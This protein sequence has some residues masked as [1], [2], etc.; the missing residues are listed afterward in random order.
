MRT[1]SR[2][3]RWLARTCVAGAVLMLWVG[4]AGAQFRQTPTS[5]GTG[6][7]GGGIGGS[8]M[9]GGF[10]GGTS[11][12]SFSGSTSGG[13]FRSGSSSSTKVGPQASDPFQ[14]FYANP[15]AFG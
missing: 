8:G 6:G 10:G 11:G 14:A 15:Y 13:S 3:C 5:G 7:T 4:A 12:G 1:F 2:D 9:S